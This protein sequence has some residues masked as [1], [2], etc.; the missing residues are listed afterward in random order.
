M[1]NKTMTIHEFMEI[2]RNK[3]NRVE[4]NTKAFYIVAI[5]IIISSLLI[6]NNLD[7]DNTTTAFQSISNLSSF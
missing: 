6:T 2:Q 3:E 1:I 4:F 5:L 7:L